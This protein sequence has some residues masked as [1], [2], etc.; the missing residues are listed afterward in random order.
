MNETERQ[1]AIQLQLSRMGAPRAA[2]PLPTGF[3]SLDA[4]LGAGGIARGVITEIFG[5]AS[6]GKTALVL[7]AIAHGQLTGSTAA[8]IDAEHAFDAAFAAHLGVD[9]SRLPVT[10][11]ES[12]EEALEMARRFAS[13]GAVDLVAVDSAAALVP[14]LELETGLGSSAAGI[15]SRVLG[16]ELR[17][18]AQVA[19]RTGTAIVL[20]N[21]TRL[22]LTTPGEGET[23]SGGPSIKLHA[24]VRLA[25]SAS[26]R[27]VRLR[28]V[29][30]KFAAPFSEAH[31]EWHR[32]RGFIEAPSI[33]VRTHPT[34]KKP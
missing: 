1:R 10:S 16:S 31:L 21:Q 11:P 28:I 33:G 13:S 20:L 29:K 9:V 2:P 32:E 4:A 3:P 6:S 26:G 18:L 24:A 30:N 17:R 12:A 27:R 19:A 25:L 34:P 8:W 14:R 7:Q 23:S 5:P 22:R 15:Q